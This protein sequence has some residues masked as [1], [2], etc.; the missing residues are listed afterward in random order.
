MLLYNYVHIKIRINVFTYV[1]FLG[2]K[3]C[4][5]FTRATSAGQ[6]KRDAD[7]IDTPL[8]IKF[9]S[10]ALPIWLVIGRDKGG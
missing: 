10:L 1:Q 6:K 7:R 9:H 8:N 3:E 4:R 2:N 5:P